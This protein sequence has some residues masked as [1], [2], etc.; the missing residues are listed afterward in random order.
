MQ[1]KNQKL[2]IINKFRKLKPNSSKLKASSGFTLIETL[3]AI[4]LLVIAITGPLQIASNA[5]NSAFYAR[6]EITSYYLAVE[7]IEYI[8]NSRDSLFMSDIFSEVGSASPWLRGLDSCIS[9]GTGEGCYIKSIVNF[10][11]ESPEGSVI[12]CEGGCPKLEY[13]SN[14]GFWGYDLEGA[15]VEETKFTRKTEIIL[16]GD[17]SAIIKVNISWPSRSLLGGDKTFELSTMITNWER[18]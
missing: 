16:I 1:I 18:I 9:D 17:N 10:N 13:S 7:A 8:K 4:T 2:K 6:D 14:T 5:L 3:V 11:P 15:N 12:L